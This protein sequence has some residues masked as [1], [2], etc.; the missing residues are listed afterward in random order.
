MPLGKECEPEPDPLPAAISNAGPL[1]GAA[2]KIGEPAEPAAR[3]RLTGRATG[4]RGGLPRDVGL[5]ATRDGGDPKGGDKARGVRAADG[6]EG[7]AKTMGGGNNGA[8]PWE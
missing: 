4:E 7:P 6:E 2:P 5:L 3:T 8:G 1:P